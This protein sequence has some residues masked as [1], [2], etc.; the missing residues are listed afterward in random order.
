MTTEKVE[1][2]AI[3]TVVIEVDMADV[4]EFIRA[5]GDYRD[6]LIEYAYIRSATCTF[7][8]SV[9]ARTIALQT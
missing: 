7:P 5:W 9:D 4:H 1:T 8:P 3:V 6:H 2:K